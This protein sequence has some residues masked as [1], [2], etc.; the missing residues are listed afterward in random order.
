[1]TLFDTCISKFLYEFRTTTAVTKTALEP[2]SYGPPAWLLIYFV[3]PGAIRAKYPIFNLHECLEE[4]DRCI[5]WLVVRA[6]TICHK[7]R[8][9]PVGRQIETVILKGNYSERRSLLFKIF[10]FCRLCA[11]ET[12]GRLSTVGLFTLQD[13]DWIRLH[14][15][16]I[17]WKST[18]PL[19]LTILGMLLSVTNH[20]YHICQVKLSL[21]NHPPQTGQ[22]LNANQA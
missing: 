9:V 15:E 2:K 5:L 4:I 18:V 10:Y 16:P 12:A 21:N 19:A 8:P 3:C 20:S 17:K 6:L 1:M 7:K 22:L 13:P 14:S 11:V